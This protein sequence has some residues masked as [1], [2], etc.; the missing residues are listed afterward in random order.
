MQL[1]ACWKNTTARL[2]SPIEAT[3][4]TRGSC[5]SIPEFH[6]T[7]AL[8]RCADLLVRHGGHSAAAGFTVKNDELPELIERLKSIAQ[9]E[10][11]DLDLRPSLT[12]DAEVSLSELTG[13]LLDDLAYIE[14]TGAKNPQAA[15]ISRGVRVLRSRTVG[16]DSSHLKLTVTDGYITYDAIAF[17]LGHLQANLP[18]VLDLLFTFEVNRF[19]GNDILQ[20]NVKDIQPADGQ[21]RFF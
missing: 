13:E 5:R 3:E 1:L 18:L 12:A 2:L 17:R 11:A 8:D 4:F 19:N 9:E 16:K 10:L 14:P 21:S 15:F 20:L 6:I 7:N